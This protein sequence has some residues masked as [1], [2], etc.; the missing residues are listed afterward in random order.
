MRRGEVDEDFLFRGHLAVYARWTEEVT[1]ID[2]GK[3]EVATA[4]DGVI[5]LE[6]GVEIVKEG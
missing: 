1:P 4:D 2:V 6:N 3:I 5:G